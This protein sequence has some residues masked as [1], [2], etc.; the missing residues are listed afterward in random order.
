MDIWTARQHLTI[1]FT[2]PEKKTGDPDPSG[3]ENT[4]DF[5]TNDD[6]DSHV[7]SNFKNDI[8]INALLIE[9]LKIVKKV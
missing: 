6:R 7:R 9:R 8:I 3:A 4:T 2:L 1:M 5:I